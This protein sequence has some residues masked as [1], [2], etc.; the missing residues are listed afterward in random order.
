MGSNKKVKAFCSKE[1]I[2]KVKNKN[3]QKHD[4]EK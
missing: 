1:T 3:K 2:G 4:K